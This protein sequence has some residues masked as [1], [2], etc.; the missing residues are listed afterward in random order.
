MNVIVAVL[1]EIPHDFLL[2]HGDLLTSPLTFEMSA[3]RSWEIRLSEFIR[4][5]RKR[6]FAMGTGGW[7]TFVDDN[8]FKQGDVLFFVLKA[9]SRFR[10][11]AGKR[12]E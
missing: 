12:P 5:E 9:Q 4:L 1:Q 11:I 10:V 6:V 7:R 3:A 2:Q 8:G